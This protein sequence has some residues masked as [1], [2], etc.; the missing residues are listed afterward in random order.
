MKA[1]CLLAVLLLAAVTVA[2]ESG[3]TPSGTQSQTAPS[4]VPSPPEKRSKADVTQNE[5]FSEQVAETLISRIARGMTRRNPKLVLSAFDA[6]KYPN[7]PVFAE[8]AAALLDQ[9][10]SFRTFYRI[11]S[12]SQEGSKASSQVDFTIERSS[13]NSGNVPVRRHAQARFGFERGAKGWRIVAMD[14]S[15]LLTK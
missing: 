7:Y 10:D 5:T 8:R 11:T 3:S 12:T 2:Q 6:A 9:F 4:S 13:K 14:P 15:D 1:K